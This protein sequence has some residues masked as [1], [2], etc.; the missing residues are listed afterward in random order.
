MLIKCCYRLIP[1]GEVIHSEYDSDKDEIIGMPLDWFNV[2]LLDLSEYSERSYLGIN[3]DY[4]AMCE[5]VLLS[6]KDFALVVE[7][8]NIGYYILDWNGYKRFLESAT[9]NTESI[10]GSVVPC[11][12]NYEAI[13]FRTTQ[14]TQLRAC[15]GIYRIVMNSRTKLI[16]TNKGVL[17]PEFDVSSLS[18]I[19]YH[20][21]G[22]KD[23]VMSGHDGVVYLNG[24][25][26]FV[27]IVD[28]KLITL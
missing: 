23:A 10:S 20:Y 28:D 11:S 16:H 12:S 22:Y 5:S 4:A 13:G 25:P 6:N 14:L 19:D 27:N 24:V 26:T 21:T 3:S 2:K 17:T 7:N 9:D 18:A 15:S 1:D 8:N